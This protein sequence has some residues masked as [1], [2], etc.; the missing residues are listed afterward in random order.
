MAILSSGQISIIDYNDAVT[1]TG[2]INTNLAKTQMYNP[3]ND[4]YNPNWASQNMVL[5]PSLFKAGNAG[6]LIASSEVQSVKW[7]IGSSSTAITANS[8]YGLSGTKSHILTIK[9]NVLAGI[10]AQDYRC[11]VTFLDSTTGLSLTHKMSVTLSRVING[12]GITDAIATTPNGS[13]F[14]NSEVSS[15]IGKIE[16]WRGSTIDT[17]NVAYQWYMMDSSVS[18]D[19]GGGTGWKKL[20]DTSGLY[21][22]CTTATL[23]IYPNAVPSYA[24]FKASIKD[25]DS[26]SATYNQ[27]FWDVVTIL[28]NSDPIQVIVESSGGDVFKNGVGS[29]TLT[30]RLFQAGVEIDTAGTAYSYRW[31]KYN[32]NGVLESSWSK[33]TKSFSIT[34]DD[35]SVK[36]TFK[37]DVSTK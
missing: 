19:Q 23:T 34:G 24:V 32:S 16:L 20:T 11:D 26:T 17:T 4:T 8:Q 2:I 33:T 35:V 13:V 31:Y 15:L 22:G 3:D 12:S 10:P 30:A 36:A 37:V 27:Y 21:T 9:A 28:D 25:T 29:S 7:Y 6:D 14:K 18:T 1:L 5:T